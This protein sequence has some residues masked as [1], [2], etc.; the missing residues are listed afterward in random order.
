M[1]LL[2]NNNITPIDIEN[3]ERL[4]INPEIRGFLKYTA[5]NVK[6]KTPTKTMVTA[7]PPIPTNPI[8]IFKLSL[9][10]N[11]SPEYCFRLHLIYLWQENFNKMMYSK[12]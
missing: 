4:P 12:L 1:S 11:L 7:S 8:N 2:T 6:N 5:D 10:I 9:I 3:E